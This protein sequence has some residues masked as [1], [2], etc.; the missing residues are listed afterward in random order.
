MKNELLTACDHAVAAAANGIYQGVLLAVLVALGLKLLGRTNAATRHGV[1]LVTLVLLAGL[2]PAHYWLDRRPTSPEAAISR[3]DQ[4]SDSLTLSKP[5]PAGAHLEAPAPLAIPAVDSEGSAGVLRPVEEEFTGSL[6]LGFPAPGAEPIPSLSSFASLSCVELPEQNGAPPASPTSVATDQSR[7]THWRKLSVQPISWNL[8]QLKFPR[9]TGAALV[10]AWLALVAIKLGWLTRRLWDLRKQKG[11]SLPAAPALEGLF[12]ALR[13]RLGVRRQVALRVSPMDSSPVVL[14][15][16]HPVVLLPSTLPWE[17]ETGEAEH[18]LRHELAHVRRRDDWANLFQRMVQAVFFFHPAIFWISRRLAIEREI[19]C[20]DHVLEHVRQPDVYALSLANLASR[21]RNFPPLLAPGASTS[22]NQLKQRI[23]MILDTR[24][25]TSPCLAKT[26]LGFI[27][28]A[29]TVAALLGLL[30]GPRLVLA[31]TTTPRAVSAPPSPPRAAPAFAGQALNGSVAPA[32]SA[33]S[34]NAPEPPAPSVSVAIEGDSGPK[35]KLG[36]ADEPAPASISVAAPVPPVP[37]APGVPAIAPVPAMPPGGALVAVTPYPMAIAG[38]PP[39]PGAPGG[40]F[41]ERLERLER[42]VRSL[43]AE[44]R[45]RRG[46]SSGYSALEQ[47]QG[48]P[49]PKDV[50]KWKEL[51]RDQGARA[52]QEAKRAA[53]EVKR[54]AKEFDKAMKDRGDLA[55]NVRK[56]ASQQ[57][58]E[59]LRRA[60]EGLQRQMEKLN[61]Q[62]QRLEQEKD[63]ADQEHPRHGDIPRGHSA[64]PSVESGSAPQAPAGET[65]QEESKP[66]AATS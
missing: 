50:E 36:D 65:I 39:P 14:G 1:W 43:M 37:P 46:A 58:L 3:A 31:Q 28:S 17:A 52:E 42:M 25:N 64:H 24:R 13:A 61:E 45:G 27:M 16:V 21:M 51:A 8:A 48:F 15:F 9:W 33:A 12:Q 29:A 66:E 34:V 56:E 2:I 54:A 57:Q 22:K 53:E 32:T 5:M 63:K 18:V 49:T 59:N 7:K 26:R 30:A 23:N 60:R 19:A 10:E 47:N 40:S 11:Q 41:E 62:I 38:T 6:F 20:D 55:R 35:Y 4:R 44:Q